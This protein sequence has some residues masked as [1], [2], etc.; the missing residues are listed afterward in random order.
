[1]NWEDYIAETWD[2]MIE[3]VDNNLIDIYADFEDVNEILDAWYDE[4][5][6]SMADDISGN[7]TG[8]YTYSRSEARSNLIGDVLISSD[9]WDY[10]HEFDMAKSIADWLVV[11]NYESVDVVVRLAAIQA[12]EPELKHYMLQKISEK[13]H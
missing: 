7:M 5:Y 11:G 2:S 9:F 10:V 8:S 3:Y 12:N 13:K 4:D 1:M 6:T